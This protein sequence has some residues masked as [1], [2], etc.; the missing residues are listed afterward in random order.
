M[1]REFTLLLLPL[2]SRKLK[3][4][5]SSL[6]PHPP[7]L[8]HTIYQALT[9]DGALAGEGFQLQGTSATP[10]GDHEGKWK[11]VSEIILGNTKWFE[12][13][14]EGERKCELSALCLQSPTSQVKSV[15]EDQ[16]HEIISASDAWLIVDD[17]ADDEDC[18]SLG[19][20]S[21]NSARKIK[22]LVEQIAG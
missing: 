5:I 2:L 19:L 10:R 7:L 6:L 20:Q 1:Q 9:F 21:T 3:H 22:A 18:S 14:L 17:D 11:G 16:Y 13:W 12:T 8:A 15:T 4:T